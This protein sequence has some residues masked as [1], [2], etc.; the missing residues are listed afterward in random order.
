MKHIENTVAYASP[1]STLL[2]VKDEV[3]CASSDSTAT[4]EAFDEITDIEW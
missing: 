2:N 4:T 3:I 1:V